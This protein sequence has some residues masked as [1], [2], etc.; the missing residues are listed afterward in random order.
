MGIR[1]PSVAPLSH[2]HMAAPLPTGS[3]ARRTWPACHARAVAALGGA[4][5]LGDQPGSQAAQAKPHLC[6]RSPVRGAALRLE[7]G[8]ALV[9][10]LGF[11]EAHK[12]RTSNHSSIA[13]LVDHLRFR[14]TEPP[15][16]SR[17]SSHGSSLNAPTAAWLAF[18]PLSC[19]ATTPS[20]ARQQPHELGR[21]ARAL[22]ARPLTSG[23]FSLAMMSCSGP[24][25]ATKVRRSSVR[26]TSVVSALT[27][28]LLRAGRA[29][30]PGGQGTKGGRTPLTPLHYTTPLHH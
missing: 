2:V 18:G 7:L 21:A 20:S 9:D 13:A 8:H 25:T 10:H 11:G 17:S 1:A 28:A 22:R 14:E 3:C 12:R 16:S 24:S 29:G 27:V 30:G 5:R 26:H 23:L 19:R 4:C 6:G 15:G